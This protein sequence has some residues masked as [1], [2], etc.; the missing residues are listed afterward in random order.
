[1]VERTLKSIVF[2]DGDCGFCNNTV[3]FILNHEK[4]DQILFTALQSDFT[5]DFLKSNNLPKPDF[6]DSCCLHP[7]THRRL[8]PPCYLMANGNLVLFPEYL[9]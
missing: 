2:Y 8:H 1:M 3:Q 5:V 6:D 9:F 4:Q 7:Y